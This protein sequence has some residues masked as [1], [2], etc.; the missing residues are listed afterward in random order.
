MF[1]FPSALVELTNIQK[2]CLF[3]GKSTYITISHPLRAFPGSLYERPF[4]L[5]YLVSYFREY[6]YCHLKELRDYYGPVVQIAPN[7][8]SY[9]L[10]LRQGIFSTHVN[11]TL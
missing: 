2:K 6:Q 8:L 4:R 10:D 3:P 5:W 9:T 1:L 11:P 7:E